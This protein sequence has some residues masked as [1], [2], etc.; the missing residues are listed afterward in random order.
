MLVNPDFHVS[1]APDGS[2]SGWGKVSM[3]VGMQARVQFH[4]QQ[5]SICCQKDMIAQTV[6]PNSTALRNEPQPAGH[7]ADTCCQ[8][9]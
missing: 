9:M 5:K 3:Q 6:L 2:C 1:C 8:S 7:S 4:T